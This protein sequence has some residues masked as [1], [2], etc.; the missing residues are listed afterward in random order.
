L[1]KLVKIVKALK[2]DEKDLLVS[3]KKNDLYGIYVQ[4]TE[5]LF[6]LELKMK[7]DVYVT[8]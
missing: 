1:K 6:T 2:I 5:M 7:K 3:K 8:F 4:I